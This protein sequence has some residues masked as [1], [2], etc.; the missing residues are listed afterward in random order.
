MRKHR[1]WITAVGVGTVAVA[2]AAGVIALCSPGLPDPATAD[3]E[4][5]LRWLVTADLGR[6]PLETRLVLARRLE[7]EF[8]E[9]VDWK[10]VGEELDAGQKARL[11]DNVLALLEPWFTDKVDAYSRLPES[12]QPAYVDRTLRLIENWKGAAA[13][14]ADAESG[15]SRQQRPGFLEALVDRIGEWMRSATP[16]RRDQAHRF[17]LAL[18]SRLFQGVT[19]GVGPTKSL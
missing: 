13:L 5:L 9:K 16:A 6:E 7:E 17:L 11:W 3:R 10:A 14:C 1:V 2:L 19:L 8:G 12:D 4:G 15:A 18:Q